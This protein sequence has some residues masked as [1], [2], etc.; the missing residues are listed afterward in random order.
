V[1][2]TRLTNREVARVLD[3]IADLLEIK[4]ENSFRIRS[5]RTGAETVGH[6]AQSVVEMV[7]RGESLQSLDGIGSGI[8]AKIQE[9]AKG[10]DCAYHRELLVEVPQGLLELLKLPGLGPRGVATLW[11]KL[12]VRSAEDL[13]AAIA[14]GRFRGLPGM[15]EKKEARLLKGLQQR[16][17]VKSRF[18]LPVAEE[19]AE[20]LRAHLLAAGASQVHAAGSFRR[21]RETIGDLDLIA[22]GGDAQKLADAFV[23]HPDAREVL[24]HG[25]EKSSVVL[26]SGLQ[27]DLRHS[28]PDSIG[29]ALQYFTGSKAHNVALRERALKRGFKLNEYGLFKT[30]SDPEERV[31]GSSE[32]EIYEALGLDYIP[33]ELREERGEIQAAE[34]RTLPVL[35]AR[36]D[37][38][39]DLHSHT[40][41]SDGRDSLEAMVEAARAAGLDYLAVTEH[42]RRVPSPSN[43]TGMDEA[44]CLAHIERVRAFESAQGFRILA[45]IEVDIL[46]DG[47]LDMDAEVLAQLDVV[48]A[49]IHSHMDMERQAMTDRL[50]RAF[51]NPR[52][53]IW[54]HPLARIL[55]RRPEISLDAE[56]VLK[57][58]A[59]RG[60]ALEINGSPDRL[61]LPDP[62]LRTAR[63]LGARFT[64]SSDSHAVREFVNLRY[65]VGQARRGGLTPDDV[66]NTRPADGLLSALRQ[67]G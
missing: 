20:K 31:A 63:E 6:H 17:E 48:V 7:E 60:I 54:G 5:Y 52:F 28:D 65:G 43:R 2:A 19:A 36:Q 67:P 39:G 23:A 10:G 24:A 58:A 64:V 49:S 30:E 57:D 26:A 14:D 3:E 1:A 66:L 59:R 12:G 40:T 38:R 21:S 4:G 61:D 27:V 9:I 13:E 29:A 41:E 47:R 46:E 25:A 34:A 55:S 37:L 18:L 51:E 32:E 11:R 45:G 8:A 50:L 56:R 53:Q 62:L 15:K 42:S 33:P 16:R 44:R 22:V 35:I